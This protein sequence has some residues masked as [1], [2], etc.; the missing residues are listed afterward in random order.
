MPPSVM[1]AVNRFYIL[2]HIRKRNWVQFAVLGVWL[3]DKCATSHS[4]KRSGNPAFSATV[5]MMAI[6]LGSWVCH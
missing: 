1:D 5:F 4:P 2:L 6:T 3:H